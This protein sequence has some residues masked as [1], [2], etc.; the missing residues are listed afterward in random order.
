VTFQRG[1]TALLQ[2]RDPYLFLA[3]GPTGCFRVKDCTSTKPASSSLAFSC[4]SLGFT[5][6]DLTV[7]SSIATP[8]RLRPLSG[9]KEPSSLRHSAEAESVPEWRNQII[10]HRCRATVERLPWSMRVS[11]CK[12]FNGLEV[13]PASVAQHRRRTTLMTEIAW[14]LTTGLRKL[15]ISTW[16]HTAICFA[17]YLR[18]FRDTYRDPIRKGNSVTQFSY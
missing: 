16:F 4:C 15:D 3:H 2:P 17:E 14:Q 13:Q 6:P 5:R 12:P 10:R 7:A 9:V 18:P 1:K 11:P 8:H